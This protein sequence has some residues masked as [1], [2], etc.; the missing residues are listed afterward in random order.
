MAAK[1]CP[2]LK[3]TRDILSP[4]SQWSANFGFGQ[5]SRVRQVIAPLS[6]SVRTTLNSA[7]V[8]AGRPTGTYKLEDFRYTGMT[9]DVRETAKSLMNF[10]LRPSW[11]SLATP[12]K[13]L[14]FSP[15]SRRSQV[16]R[17]RDLVLILD[18]SGS[19]GTTSFV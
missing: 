4:W 12:L 1:P 19:I 5:Q 3:E 14:A 11:Q 2:P 10:F 18:S 15:V 13:S 17:L 8:G 9:P 6:N 7:S 16:P